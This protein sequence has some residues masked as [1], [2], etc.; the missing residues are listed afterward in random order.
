MPKKP[1]KTASADAPLVTSRQGVSDRIMRVGKEVYDDIVKKSRKPSL[2]QG[3]SPGL[4]CENF[5]VVLS[6]MDGLLE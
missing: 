5:I 2:R 4:T 6:S 1:V 3:V